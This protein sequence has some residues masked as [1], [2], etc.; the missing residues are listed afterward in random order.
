MASDY[1]SI[2]EDNIK[3]RGTE[4]DDIGTLISEQLYSDRTHFIF[5]LLQNAE[6]ALERRF[7]NDP[8]SKLARRVKFILYDDRLE[9]RHF[10]QLFTED[11]VKSICDVLKGT[12]TDDATQIGRFGIGF[13]SVYAFTSS[14]RIHSGDEHFIIER[15]IRPDAITPEPGLAKDETLFV[16]PFDHEKHL[17]KEAFAKI[18]KRLRNLG[19]EILLFLHNIDEIEW[20]NTESGNGG[21]YSRKLKVKGDSR[22]ISV[23]STSRDLL[24]EEQW[25]IFRSDVSSVFDNAFVEVAFKLVKDAESKKDTIQKLTTSPLVAY[26]PTELD[27][28]LG[29][30]L[31]GPFRTTPARDNLLKEDQCNINLVKVA[32]DFIPHLLKSIKTHGLL[33]VNFLNTLPLIMS[34]H[35]DSFFYP[36]VEAIRLALKTEELLPTASGSFTNAKSARLAENQD[37]RTLLNQKTLQNMFLSQSK[38]KWLS[39][40]INNTDTYALYNY[41]V[42]ELDITTVDL[43]IILAC[44]NNEFLSQQDDKWIMSLY[45]YFLKQGEYWIIDNHKLKGKPIIRLS[46]NTH[47]EP[48]DYNGTPN[49]YLPIAEESKSK[50]PLVKPSIANNKNAYKFLVRLGLKEV[51]I[52]AEVHAIILPRYMRETGTISQRTHKTDI[53]K[54]FHAFKLA[55]KEDSEALKNKLQ[56]TPFILSYNNISK[57]KEYKRPE[58]T[59]IGTSQLKQYFAGSDEVWF[60]KKQYE[61]NAI[62]LFKQ[63]GVADNVRVSRNLPGPDGQVILRKRHRYHI[64][65]LGGF[66]PYIEVDGLQNAISLKHKAVSE[67]IWNTIAIRH[68]TCVEGIIEES[69]RQDYSNSD[70]REVESDFGK[71]LRNCMW[72]PDKKGKF[73][74]PNKLKL[75]DLPRSFK[76]DDK[77]AQALGMK[78]DILGRLA[79][80]A[81]VSIEDIKLAKRLRKNPKIRKE[82]EDRLNSQLNLPLFPVRTSNN[83][84]RRTEK[85]QRQYLEAVDKKYELKNRS[86]RSTK[87]NIDPVIWLRNQYKNESDELICQICKHEMPFKK[88]NGDYYFEHVEIFDRHILPKEHE[89]Q[90]IALCPLCAAK[91]KE[92]VKKEIEAMNQLKIKLIS[93]DKLE[94]PIIF[95]TKDCSIEFVETHLH[96]IKVILNEQNDS[97]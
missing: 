29:F 28:R 15:Y 77:L 82:F 81:G 17:A 55:S 26:F 78:K 6:D 45:R 93:A 51:D 60:V 43:N 16:F 1:K 59:Y 91:Y 5:E 94:V 33:S 53:K 25:L 39:G 38:L 80:K 8:N 4:F 2:R 41:M 19:P 58:E 46:D 64:R 20:V 62:W 10:G 14:P 72:L 42:Y 83:P 97:E 18:S 67:Y 40:E 79:K 69:P 73:Q 3:R 21:T 74:R 49:A 27:T 47:V 56:Q 76:R 12:K 24:K 7:A 50:T 84:E 88:R 54:I 22:H 96:D 35:E 11:D 9:F 34:D 37:I 90:F 44:L 66:D 70:K 32:V 61:D 57:G 86:N 13:K 89:A 92:F 85:V 68:A 23:T 71:T 52:V 36:I 30:L 31:Q 87:S 75:E 95:D 48:F 65:G 63:L